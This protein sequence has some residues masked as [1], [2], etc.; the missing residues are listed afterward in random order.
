MNHLDTWGYPPAKPTK[1]SPAP[2]LL[3]LTLSAFIAGALVASYAPS[4]E[5]FL[6]PDCPTAAC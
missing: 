2:I 3:A 1:K 4:G 5:R 6:H